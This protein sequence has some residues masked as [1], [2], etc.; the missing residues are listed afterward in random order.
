MDRFV[1]KVTHTTLSISINLPIF[2][3][4]LTLI[5]IILV[6]RI[7]TIIINNIITTKY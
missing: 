3:I 2:Y 7:I 1:S 4:I 5:I 6:I